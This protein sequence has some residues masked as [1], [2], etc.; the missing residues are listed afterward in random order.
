MDFTIG[1]CTHNR[2]NDLRVTLQSLRQ[3]RIPEGVRHEILVVDN[4]STDG[5]SAVASGFTDAGFPVRLVREARLGVCAARNRALREAQRSRYLLFLDDDVNVRR[6]LLATLL[7]QRPDAVPAAVRSRAVVS[8]ASTVA[9]IAPRTAMRTTSL[10]P[11]LGMA[12][13]GT[14]SIVSSSIRCTPR[15]KG[16][17]KRPVV[18]GLHRQ[19]CTRFRF[20]TAIGTPLFATR[21][22]ISTL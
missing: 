16:L 15:R 21:T 22:G 7:D 14:A 13:A 5:T 4:A 20:S 17:R 9:S 11:S 12:S 6:D 8:S 10:S 3:L 1:I 18:K 19:G 2:A